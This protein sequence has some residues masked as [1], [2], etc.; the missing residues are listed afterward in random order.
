MTEVQHQTLR[1]LAHAE[2][3]A[4]EMIRDAASI[5]VPAQTFY[6]LLEEIRAARGAVNHAR[7]WKAVEDK[8][9]VSPAE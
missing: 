1:L 8:L 9:K 2:F 4:E 7:T 3:N 6:G 5:G